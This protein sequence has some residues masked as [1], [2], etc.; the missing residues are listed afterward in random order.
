MTFKIEDTGIG[1]SEVDQQHVF[2]RFYKADKSRTRA[3]NSGSGLGL[4]IVQK[5]VEMHHGTITVESKVGVGTTFVVS[6][7]LAE[8]QKANPVEAEQSAA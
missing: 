2:E 6:L 3:N 4:S 5:I 7:P 8:T 1:I